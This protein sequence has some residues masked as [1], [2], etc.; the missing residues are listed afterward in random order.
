GTSAVPL[1]AGHP[2]RT[3]RNADPEWQPRSGWHLPGAVPGRLGAAGYRR[4]GAAGREHLPDPRLLASPAL[5]RLL[6]RVPAVAG[7]LPARDEP[8]RSLRAAEPHQHRS[9]SAGDDAA[10]VQSA[11]PVKPPD[12]GA[13]ADQSGGE[14][15]REDAGWDDGEEGAEVGD[16]CWGIGDGWAWGLKRSPIPHPSP[17]PQHPS[18]TAYSPWQRGAGRM[19]A[20][21]CSWPL[22]LFVLSS[23]DDGG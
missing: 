8:E 13:R 20:P 14:C 7:D 4:N 3:G 1:A 2:A 6:E 5:R 17:I 15:E 10:G 21:R 12:R 19:P 9:S 16:G 23:A 11:L 22:P 18:P